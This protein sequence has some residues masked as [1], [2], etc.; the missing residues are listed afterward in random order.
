MAFC[1]VPNQFKRVGYWFIRQFKWICSRKIKLLIFWFQ[2]FFLWYIL[3]PWY[4][5]NTS[6]KLTF[7]L[8]PNQKYK[9]VVERFIR[10]FKWICS[11]KIKICFF[12]L[13]FSKKFFVT[14]LD[15]E[16]LEWYIG[17]SGFPLTSKLI[18]MCG[19]MCELAIQMVT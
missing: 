18:Q 13:S 7:C 15:F 8:L 5:D 9:T 2:S 16:I 11:Q 6:T 17:W 3:C 12:E 10:R 4:Q 1:L 14:F 19:L